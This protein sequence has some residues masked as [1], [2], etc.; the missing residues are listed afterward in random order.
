LVDATPRI[1]FID[2]PT[3]ITKYIAITLLLILAWAI[4][5][6][7]IFRKFIKNVYRGNIFT[8]KNI[9]L[10]KKLAYGLLGLWIFGV[11]Y[12][13]LG[14]HILAKNLTFENA[15]ITDETPNFSGVLLTA[16]LVW[17]LAHIFEKGLELKQESDLTI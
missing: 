16:L 3:Y 12:F 11:F 10:L 17:V 15:K 13:N 1:H 8:F 2:T 5:E 14:Y 9:Q 6:I 4:F 7:Y